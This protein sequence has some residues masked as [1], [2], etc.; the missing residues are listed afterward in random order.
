[1]NQQKHNK[2]SSRRHKQSDTDVAKISDVTA[3]DK[4]KHVDEDKDKETAGGQW[5]PW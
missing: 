2:I 5:E 1:M 3:A 4:L